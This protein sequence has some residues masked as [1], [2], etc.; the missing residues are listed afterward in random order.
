MTA[1]AR[2]AVLGHAADRAELAAVL[3]SA[4]VALLECPLPP[5]D[6]HEAGGAWGEAAVV[7]VASNSRDDAMRAYLQASGVIPVARVHQLI[8]DLGGLDPLTVREIAQA[9][10]DAGK[11]FVDVRP[12]ADGLACWG[13]PPDAW[14]GRGSLLGVL[15]APES[16]VG[17][18]GSATVAA[19]V[20][21]HVALVNLAGS[22][23]GL[24]LG[25]RAGM[26][27]EPLTQVIALSSGTSP[28]LTAP[29]R[30]PAV[31]GA[32]A[33]LT[34]EAARE[35][36]EQVLDLGRRSCVP[37]PLA[38]LTHGWLQSLCRQG[39]GAEPVAALG[40]LFRRLAGQGASRPPGRTRPG[41]D[42]RGGA[43]AD[44]PRGRVG[45][46]GLGRMGRPMA[47]SILRSGHDLMVHNRSSAAVEELAALG[48]RTASRP[49][50]IAE[51]CDVV[52]TCLPHNQALEDVYW[53]EDGL[54]SGVHEGQEL[55]DCGTS[56]LGLTLRI[57]QAV[58]ERGALFA[59]APVSGGLDKAAAGELTIMVGASE[60]AL[61]FGRSVLAAM[62]SE[63]F[64]L[65]E[66][67]RGQVTKQVNNM[68]NATNFA[69]ACEG[70]ALAVAAGL[71]V[72]AAFALLSH[73]RLAS[74]ALTLRGPR[75]LRGEYA[76]TYTTL[77]RIKD[78]L[79]ALE[80]GQ[81]FRVP[82]PLCAI[83]HEL[84]EATVALGWGTH[85]W[86]SL[87]KVYELLAGVSLSQGAP[88]AP[89]IAQ[90]QGNGSA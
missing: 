10:R 52:V 8:V 44:Q 63:L 77:L 71:R 82:L 67:G 65:D 35:R 11:R 2:V 78:S 85:D 3:R 31:G 64:F 86:T 89:P 88:P 17:P 13:G 18:A 20:T 28:S 9:A 25:E 21:A 69:A 72:E 30:L 24:V 51:E 50:Q 56:S 45:F 60:P 39:S 58:R 47:S 66:L 1:P 84:F 83:V 6:D 12:V 29:L 62:G 70:L 43:A 59:D 42:R 61:G 75:V 80:L 40:D 37:T 55:I 87:A 53:G 14:S 7:L 23:E 26:E 5:S 4:G 41:F 48:A 15:G 68:L 76:A 22:H 38:A 57:A 27:P 90:R 46:I 36:L 49:R 81:E 16:P 34:V 32:G 79:A 19:A 73:P 74:F 33:L 54:L